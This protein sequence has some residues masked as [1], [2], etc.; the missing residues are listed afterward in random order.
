ME[1]YSTFE[2][3]FLNDLVQEQWQVTVNSMQVL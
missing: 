3:H 2:H 1:R